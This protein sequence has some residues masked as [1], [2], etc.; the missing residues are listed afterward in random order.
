MKLIYTVIAMLAVSS[1]AMA[2]TSAVYGDANGDGVVSSTDV[3]VIYNYLLFGD[4][5]YYSTSD[6]DGDGSITSG[7]VTVVYNILLG[8][9]PGGDNHEY[10]DLGLPSGT[11]WAT[12]NVGASTPE[13]CGDYFSWGETTPRGGEE[14][15]WNN[16]Q[17]S[18]GSRFNKLINYCPNSQ[19]GYNGFSDNLTELEPEDDA[20]TVNWGSNW[21]TPSKTQMEELRTKCTWT[22]TTSNG[23][24]GYRVSK[25]GKSI[26]LPVTDFYSTGQIYYTG[27]LG[28]YWTR[29]LHETTS[30]QAYY[31]YFYS[32]S[33]LKCTYG[34]RYS[35]F[36]VRAVR[37]QTH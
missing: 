28:Y 35:G 22:W 16:Y 31:L 34:N 14:P 8:I 12:M 1:V 2:Q 17:W 10:V 6:V 33:N 13:E 7:D 18:N 11:L 30:Y 15:Y 9:I 24:K 27:F 25:N 32:S 4:M 3:T 19:Y 21:Q 23:V 26:F 37:K 29:T 36:A 5:T 20:A